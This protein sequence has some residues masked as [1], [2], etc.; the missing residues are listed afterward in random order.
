MKYLMQA[1]IVMAAVAAP[2][3]AKI[4]GDCEIVQVEGANYFAK[5]DPRCTFAS[6]PKADK[7]DRA[8]ALG[9]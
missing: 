5:V 2:A 6:F 1:M 8:D 7:D 9:N 4:V 3:F